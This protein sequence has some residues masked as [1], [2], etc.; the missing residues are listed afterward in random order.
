[1]APRG[2]QHGGWLA[3][4]TQP[5]TDVS[6][7][8]TLA[9]DM[10]SVRPVGGAERNHRTAARSALGVAQVGSVQG[11]ADASVHPQ[12]QPPTCTPISAPGVLELLKR[13]Q[14]LCALS[15][16]PLTPESA[17]LDHI[18]PVRVGGQHIIENAQI[19]DKD[20]NR[21]KNALTNA[22]FLAMCR[23]VVGWCGGDDSPNP[24]GPKHPPSMHPGIPAPGGPVAGSVR[25][26]A[27]DATWANVGG[28]AANGRG[29]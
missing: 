26:P 17:A 27:Q 6:A 13:Q 16:R 12:A 29:P 23:E 10:G 5:A 11:D 9:S 4:P 8:Q 20:V 28:P 22:E 25:R 3:D 19:L 18:V 1:M 2:P 15:G 14:Y 7:S 21:A 24:G